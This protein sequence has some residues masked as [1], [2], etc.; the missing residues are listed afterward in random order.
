MN[1]Q[2]RHITHTEIAA[3]LNRS[4]S[5]LDD[6]V[7]ASLRQARLNALQKRRTRSPAYSL[8]V[9][10]DHVHAVL[11]PHSA[12][13]WFATAALI[14]TIVVGGANLWEYRQAQ[15]VSHLDIA[16]LTDDMPMEVFID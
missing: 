8:A 15:S 1:T 16:I 10:S 7:A 5:Q 4:A 13:Q 2:E 3:M 12:G 14:F 11:T 9:I 6:E